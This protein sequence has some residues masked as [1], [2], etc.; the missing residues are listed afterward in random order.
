MQEIGVTLFI[1]NPIQSTFNLFSKRSQLSIIF[2][3]VLANI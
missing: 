3:Q 1:K 2:I